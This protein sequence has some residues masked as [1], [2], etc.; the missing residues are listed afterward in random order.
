[1]IQLPVFQHISIDD[2]QLYPGTDARPGIDLEIGSGLTL[3]LGANGLGKT[4]FV[5]MLYRVLSGTQDIPSFGNAAALGGRSLDVR[6]R[7]RAEQR[8]FADRVSDGAESATATLTFLMGTDEVTVRRNLAD[9]SLEAFSISGQQYEE[10]EQVFQEEIIRRS[11]LASFGDWILT[12]RHLIFYFEDRQALIW[13][14]TAQRQLLRLLFLPPDVS[15]EWTRREREV[16]ELDSLVR[17]LQYGLNKETK[18]LSK[19]TAA[20]SNADEVRQSL[21]L[22]AGMQSKEQEQLDTLTDQLAELSSRRSAARLAALTVDQDRQ[23]AFKAI[24]R[25]ELQAIAANFPDTSATARYLLSQIMSES[26]C[27]TC[28]NDVPSFR[29]KLEARLRDDHCIVC[30]SHVRRSDNEHAHHPRLLSRARDSAKKLEVQSKQA[31]EALRTAEL[32]HADALQIVSK[33]TATTSERAVSI[34]ELI[35]QLPPNERDVHQQRDAMASMRANVEMRREE[36]NAKRHQFSNFVANVN[37]RI[38]QQR[39]AIKTAFDAYA[40]GFLVEDC[41]LAWQPRKSRVGE[42]GELVEFAAFELAMSGAGFE[43]STRRTGPTQV[44]ESQREFIDLSFRMSLMEVAATSGGSL[45]IDAPESSL[46]AVFVSRAA[47]VLTNYASHG[48]NRLVVTSNLVDGDLIPSLLRQSK[49]RSSRDRRVVDLLSIAAPTAATRQLDSEY[50]K[51]RRLL[52][53]RARTDRQ[54]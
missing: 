37:E 43:S 51:V 45:V 19:A 38:A 8:T 20:L 29:D 31:S 42:T 46:D 52:F 15:A 35:Q 11:G 16:L 44:S 47:K 34:D 53:A 33:L 10:T 9:L 4:T 21:T 25:L 14:A 1:M 18:R 23:S 17:N 28:G 3:V 24:E 40:K 13:D 5:T 27:L 36:L 48:E 30:D 54:S 41:E 49:I 39:D 2:Y 26:R 12:L 50:R 32:E 6:T 7:S 22:L